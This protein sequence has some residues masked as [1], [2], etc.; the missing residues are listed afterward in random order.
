MQNGEF[1]LFR[2]GRRGFRFDI[3]C[4]SLSGQSG[5]VRKSR[6]CMERRE[7][8]E[9]SE[10]KEG[11][12]RRQDRFVDVDHVVSPLPRTLLEHFS[13]T[14]VDQRLDFSIREHHCVHPQASLLTLM[15]VFGC[16]Q[17]TSRMPQR[18]LAPLHQPEHNPIVRAKVA[19]PFVS[20]WPFRATTVPFPHRTATNS[21]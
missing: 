7:G 14:A 18:K 20:A 6:G 13:R 10:E 9:G 1:P 21:M 12:G 19:F 5:C 2:A 11:R 16:E 3:G 17:G 15:V 4:E 8:E